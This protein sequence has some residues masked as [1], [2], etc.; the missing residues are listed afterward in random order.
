MDER[1]TAAGGIF[2]PPRLA[3]LRNYRLDFSKAPGYGNIRRA[4]GDQTYGFL[5]E[6]NVTAFRL[7]DGYEGCRKTQQVPEGCEPRWEGHYYRMDCIVE[8]RGDADEWTEVPAVTYKAHIGVTAAGQMPSEEYL[9][10]L[11]AG[12]ALLPA[13][14]IA[15]IIEI[16]KS[17][18]V[19]DEDPAK[20]STDV[21]EVPVEQN[22]AENALKLSQLCLCTIEKAIEA[23]TKTD[24]DF[25]AAV[26]V[27][28][29][30]PS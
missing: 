29:N 28:F 10:H 20:G 12:K 15:R 11:L 14:Y 23:L 2:R 1:I 25:N 22:I 3:R 26:D 7:L 9:S 24:G 5:Y 30:E 18:S 4:A 19:S 27:L 8:V 21:V 6:M 13:E 16:S 17:P